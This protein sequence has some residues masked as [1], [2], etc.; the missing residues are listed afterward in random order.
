MR[1]IKQIVEEFTEDVHLPVAFQIFDVR[2]KA[3]VPGTDFDLYISSGGPGSPID[4][5]GSEWEKKYFSLMDEL[6]DHNKSNPKRAKHVML[7]CH[8]F[9]VFCRY[10][11]Y[12]KVSERRTMS[13]GVMPVHKTTEGHHDQLL[14]SLG[15]PF[16]GVDSRE[17]QIIE[18]DFKKIRESGA[19]I[20]CIEKFRPHV[21]FERAIMG[22]RFNDFMI[23][24]QFHPEA[25]AEGMK[26]YFQ[27]EDKKQVVIARHGEKKFKSMIK[28]LEDPDKI[29]ATYH[30]VIPRFLTIGAQAQ[31]KAVAQ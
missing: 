19:K 21:S 24:L 6:L 14:R 27:R 25:D 30:T 12:A 29:L 1:C 16:W 4:S 20:L 3:E 7:I 15:D 26:M 18:P 13:F 23:G 17:Y 10:Y 9:Q 5:V 28:H 8:S 2:G 31:L 22:I 11:G